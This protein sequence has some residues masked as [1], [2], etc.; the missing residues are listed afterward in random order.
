MSG[1]SQHMNRQSEGAEDIRNALL[2]QAEGGDARTWRE[3]RF[4][5][6]TAG[7][8][9]IAAAFVVFFLFDMVRQGYS[10]LWQ[11]RVRTTVTYTPDTVQNPE[12]AF[13]ED[14]RDIVSPARIRDVQRKGQSPIVRVTLDLEQATPGHPEQAV[15]D[16]TLSADELPIYMRNNAPIRIPASTVRQLIRPDA[17]ESVRSQFKQGTGSSRTVSLT[18][19]EALQKYMISQ[20]DHPLPEELQTPVEQMIKAGRIQMAF[21]RSRFGEK[22]MFDRWVVLDSDVDQY[23]KGQPSKVGY[24][25]SEYER[26]MNQLGRKPVPDPDLDAIMSDV[27]SS[28]AAGMEEKQT[29]TEDANPSN[30]IASGTS[31]RTRQ[32]GEKHIDLSSTSRLK[33]LINGWRTA[34]TIDELKASGMVQLR[35]NRFF[36]FNGDSSEHPEVAGMKSALIGSVLVLLVVLITAVPIGVLTSVYLEEFAPDNWLTQLI[37]INI[38]NLAAIPSILYGLL[39]LAIFINTIGLGRSVVLV[40][41]LTLALMTLPIVIISS[42]SALRSV[43]D[44]TRM[45]GFSMGATRWQVVLHHVL[46]ESIT[47]ILTGSIIGLAQAM[48]ETAP[49]ILIGM[50]GFFPDAPTSILDKSTVMPA[51]IFNWWSLPQRAFQSRAALAILLLL[52]VLFVMNGVAVVLRART[53]EMGS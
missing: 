22:S 41:G 25:A 47:G 15:Q 49:L 4:R 27:K 38:N 32:R 42:R 12:T 24:R 45:A 13:P 21:N 8:L 10:A 7:A 11:A 28:N 35:F 33:E 31:S 23:V 20:S 29:S 16:V 52:A 34:R 26:L 44:S 40:G 30:S 19:S 53:Q 6:Y 43:P 17:F 9:I 14:V 3:R 46:P 48:G 18:G 36:F 1:N 37:E 39:G 51:Q 5:M 50:V 2:G